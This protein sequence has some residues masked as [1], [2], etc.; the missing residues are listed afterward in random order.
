MTPQSK[1]KAGGSEVGLF[2]FSRWGTGARESGSQSG[3]PKPSNGQ[4]GE[5]SG[6][7]RLLVLALWLAVL[8]FAAM[9]GRAAMQ[10]DVFL[11]YDGVVPEATWFP[12][13]FEIK[14]DG[15]P[16]VG[17]VELTTENMNQDQ[18]RRMVVELPTGTLK[19][20]V[21]PVFSTT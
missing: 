19:R 2:S 6:R 20:F 14:N 15:P 16:F 9:S 7:H 12:L 5:L 18:A 11:G 17:T 8:C 13:L 1:F 21:L 4:A 10:F 3:T